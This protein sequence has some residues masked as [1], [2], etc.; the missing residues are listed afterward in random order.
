MCIH[1][2]IEYVATY[3]KGCNCNWFI[4]KETRSKRGISHPSFYLSLHRKMTNVI[5]QLWRA[6]FN[7]LLT[8]LCIIH[9]HACSL[10]STNYI[11]TYMLKG[12]YIYLRI[13]NDICSYKFARSHLFRHTHTY[14]Q[15]M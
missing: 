10:L 14:T 5:P 12:S 6:S 13:L 8:L 2:I 3:H 9:M 15:F 11:C 1:N 4:G 7:L